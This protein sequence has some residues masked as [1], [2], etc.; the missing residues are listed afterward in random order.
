M[1]A[2]L[3]ALIRGYQYLLRPLL[4]SNCRF[5]PSCS[6]YAHEAIST[7][8]ILR[9]TWLALRRVLRCHPYHPGGYDPVPEVQS[10]PRSS[11][12]ARPSPRG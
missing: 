10:S 9:G 3:L 7:H 11:P 2:L 6:E 5:A 1:R 4:G 8:G 12:S